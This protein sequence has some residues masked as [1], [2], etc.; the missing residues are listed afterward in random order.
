MQARRFLASLFL[1]VPAAT[2]AAAQNALPA[3]PGGTLAVVQTSPAAISTAPVTSA[4]TVVFDR[5]VALD[6]L[7]AASF[8]VFGRYSGPARGSFA[9]TNGARRVTFVPDAL[10]SAG[11]VV[12][13]NLAHSIRGL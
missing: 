8:R 2:S 5:P 13:V 3:G 12:W 9:F 10:F 7:D 1:L 6:T 11:E 4:I